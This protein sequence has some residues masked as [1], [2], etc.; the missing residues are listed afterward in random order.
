MLDEMTGK[1]S[2]CD[3]I[4]TTLLRTAA[5]CLLVSAQLVILSFAE[6]SF[7]IHFKIAQVTSIVNKDSLD[8]S[9]PASYRPIF[10]LNT[11]SKFLQRLFLARLIPHVSPS[12]CPL[13]SA[14]GQFHSRDSP[15]KDHKWLVWSRRVQLCLHASCPRLVG[16]FWHHGLPVTCVEARAHIQCQGMTLG[17]AK[18]YLMLTPAYHKYPFW[19]N[20]FFTVHQ[21]TRRCHIKFRCQILPVHLRHEDLPVHKQR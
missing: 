17:W 3:F 20:F 1:S 7:P 4:L 16:S 9:S 2:L 12:I 10:N 5:V 19:A 6:G 8:I 11:I 15:V 21:P 18:S 13:Q 14:Y